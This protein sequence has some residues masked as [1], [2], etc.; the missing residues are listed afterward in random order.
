M[1]FASSQLGGGGLIIIIE[2]SQNG[3]L[4]IGIHI[5]SLEVYLDTTGFVLK[6][7][8]SENFRK[9]LIMRL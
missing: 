8:S 2:G 9:S 5:K 3:F 7:L 6:V 1:H 4:E